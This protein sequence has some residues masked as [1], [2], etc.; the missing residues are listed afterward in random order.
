MINAMICRYWQKKIMFKGTPSNF[1]ALLKKF[2][3]NKS[4]L[5]QVINAAT[6]H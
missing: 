4:W 1:H 6:F 5:L 2:H 3:I